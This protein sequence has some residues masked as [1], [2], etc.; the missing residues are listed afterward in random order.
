MARLDRPVTTFS[1]GTLVL[2]LALSA[3]LSSP[4]AG[5]LS[6]EASPSRQLQASPSPVLLIGR[7][8]ASDCPDGSTCLLFEVN[9]GGQE[10]VTGVIN[11]Q[12]PRDELLRLYRERQIPRYSPITLRVR[13]AAKQ[14]IESPSDHGNNWFLPYDLPKGEE[15]EAPETR[16]ELSDNEL[17][18]T[19]T[20]AELLRRLP[21][22]VRA[23]AVEVQISVNVPTS[24]K[25][26]G[27]FG[28]ECEW[29]PIP[30]ELRIDQAR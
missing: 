28:G 3:Y 7:A 6:P 13:D 18:V 2:T 12:E 27:F 14:I 16:I 20:L 22:T 5:P 23:R 9:K 29:F 21:D 8:E 10:I 26:D 4:P 30:L 25:L 19:V 17:R 24:A 15:K 11:P 1:L